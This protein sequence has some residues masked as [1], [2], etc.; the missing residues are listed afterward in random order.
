[1]DIGFCRLGRT[2]YPWNLPE[3]ATRQRQSSFFMALSGKITAMIFIYPLMS[4]K[5]YETEPVS[6]SSHGLPGIVA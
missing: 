5:T 4:C 1:M 6:C 2:A 3:G